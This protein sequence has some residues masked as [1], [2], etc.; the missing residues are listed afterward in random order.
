MGYVGAD[1]APFLVSVNAVALPSVVVSC[2]SVAPPSSW[3]FPSLASSGALSTRYPTGHCLEGSFHAVTMQHALLT[4]VSDGL[5]TCDPILVPSAS[6]SLCPHLELEENVVDEASCEAVTWM[7]AS[8]SI[9]NCQKWCSK[10]QLCFHFASSSFP[11]SFHV[12]KLTIHGPIASV[13]LF[14][15]QLSSCCDQHLQEV[16]V[17]DKIDEM[18]LCT[19]DLP[20]DSAGTGS[21]EPS[22]W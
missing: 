3:H 11:C 22:S 10:C 18:Y 6:S 14:F 8:S 1:A 4:S 7:A 2:A 13:I 21:F 5:S 17:V 12:D 20:T 16:V 15:V 19:G 9:L